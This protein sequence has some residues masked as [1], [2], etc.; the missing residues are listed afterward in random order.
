MDWENCK[1][2]CIETIRAATISIQINEQV[3]E[4]CNLKIGQIKTK[5]LCKDED[6]TGPVAG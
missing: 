3:L 5:D 4:F 2:A 1:Q 6:K